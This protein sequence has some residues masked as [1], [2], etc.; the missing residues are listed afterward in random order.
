METNEPIPKA[1]WDKTPK[2]VKGLVK[3]LVST[4]EKV[5]S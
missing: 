2:S 4:L 5:V 1:D 3:Q